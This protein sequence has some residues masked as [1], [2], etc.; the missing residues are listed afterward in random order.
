MSENEGSSRRDALK[1]AGAAILGVAAVGV[2]SPGT[3][4][5]AK[6][7]KRWAMVIDLRK[8]VGC[9]TCTIACKAEFDVPLGRWNAVIKEV[10]SGSYPNTQKQFMPRLCNHCA[11]EKSKKVPP[12][13]EKCPEAKSGKR[14]KQDGVSYRT[15]ATYKRPD[16]MI[17]FD[18][19]LCIGCYK[20]IKA[21]PYGVRYIDPAVKLDKPNKEADFGIGKCTFCDHRVDNGVEPSCVQSCPQ[22]ARTF[23]DMMDSGSAVSKLIKKHNLSTK[24]NTILPGE[25][26]DPHV[27]YIEH[28]GTLGRYKFDHK[29]EKKKAAEFRDHI[30]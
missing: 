15:G 1:G 8:C 13:V 30:V 17:L 22:Y 11:G 23:G 6:A 2:L 9:R 19:K 14:A 7:K 29:D 12:C 27:F 16:G 3:V 28:K 5:A 26:T 21:C 18:N 20:C 4:S 10:D 24:K 25:K